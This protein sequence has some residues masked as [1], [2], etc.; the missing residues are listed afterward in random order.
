YNRYYNPDTGR[1]ITTDPLGLTPSPNPH[2]YVTNPTTGID[3]LGLTSCGPHNDGDD[4]KTA[5]EFVNLA[6]PS[7]TTHI[8]QGDATGGGHLWPGGP[9]KSPFP[10]SWSGDRIMHEISDI[11]TDPVAWRGAVPQGGR[12][13][14]TGTRDGVDIRVVVDT[15]TGEIVTGYPTNVARNP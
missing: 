11:A 12:T 3:P 4:T 9:G 2:T 10:Q 5:D 14:L 7:R 15:R 6:S 1:Y 8:L 13:V